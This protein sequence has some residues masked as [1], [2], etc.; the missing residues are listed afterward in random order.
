MWENKCNTQIK[1]K[2]HNIMYFY[3]H[4]GKIVLFKLNWA[5]FFTTNIFCI[6]EI[7]VSIDFTTVM[8]NSPW[9]TCDLVW[10]HYKSV[11]LWLICK[12]VIKKT[13]HVKNTLMMFL[14]R[15]VS[16]LTVIS[17][18]ISPLKFKNSF[19]FWQ[20]KLNTAQISMFPTSISYLVFSKMFHKAVKTA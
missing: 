13:L 15:I 5:V 9:F 17:N 19:S 12:N 18:L 20:I 11:Q 3:D 6:I 14:F 16:M 10:F 2:I 7:T 4:C 1:L 8:R